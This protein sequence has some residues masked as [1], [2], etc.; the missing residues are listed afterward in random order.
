[1]SSA[2]LHFHFLLLRAKYL[3]NRKRVSFKTMICSKAPTTQFIN[4]VSMNIL[5]CDNRYISESII[6]HFFVHTAEGEDILIK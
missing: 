6:L 2:S 5:S 4:A 1:M 3:W